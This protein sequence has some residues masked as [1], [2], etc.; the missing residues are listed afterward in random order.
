MAD[1]E[2]EEYTSPKGTVYSVPKGTPIEK[3][4]E[5]FVSQGEME[6]PKADPMKVEAPYSLKEFMTSPHGFIRSGIADIRH[7]FTPGE[8]WQGRA[9]DVMEGGQKLLTPVGIGAAAPAVAA[10]G[11]PAA[12][13]ILGS[14]GLGYGA[15]KAADFATAQSDLSPDTKR[16]IGDVAGVGGAVA[17]GGLGYGVS[18]PIRLSRA[19]RSGVEETVKGNLPKVLRRFTLPS[20]A[21]AAVS[22]ATG[23]GPWLG[24]AIGEAAGQ[25]PSF[26]R[27]FRAGW[28]GGEPPV[29]YSG[30]SSTLRAKYSRESTAG[31][32]TFQEQA[33]GRSKQGYKPKERGEESYAPSTQVPEADEAGGF[34]FS[35]S[36]MRKYR[37]GSTSGGKT[38][39][40]Q[41]ARKSR[42]SAKGTDV[43]DEPLYPVKK[44]LPVRGPKGRYQKPED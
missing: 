16:L 40:E 35:S 33:A 11:I 39:T 19:L 36:I 17:G 9:A 30:P 32:E 5:L 21:G 43:P 22:S 44:K 42:V 14:L 37:V 27:G 20:L 1:Q 29:E 4:Q 7:A 13:S 23:H 12:A 2:Y 15:Q 3:V 18:Q 31:G 26:T 24:G 6:A 28:K 38:F 34:K 10:G 41:S 8:S 25:I